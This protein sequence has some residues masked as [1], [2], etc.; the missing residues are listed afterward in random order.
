M[1]LDVH[2]TTVAV[3][4]VGTGF[5]QSADIELNLGLLGFSIKNLKIYDAYAAGDDWD[6][7]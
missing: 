2:G 5:P 7:L 3:A 6:G 4:F 1:E